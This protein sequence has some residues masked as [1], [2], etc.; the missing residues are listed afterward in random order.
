MQIVLISALIL[1]ILSLPFAYWEQARAV[2][3]AV[4]ITTTVATS[5]TFTTS[6]GT[7]DEFGTVT[8]GTP[9]FATTTLAVATN[10]NLGWLTSLSGDNK[11]LTN[12]NLQ[13]GTPPATSTQI[14]DQTEWIPGTATTSAGNA[15]RITSLVNSNNVLAFRVMTASSTNGAP[16][17][18]T[19]WWGTADN[20]ADNA[21]TLWS[22]VPS[23][24]VQ[25]TIGNAGA[26]SYS[27]STHINTVLYYLNT[28]P[29]QLTGSYSAPLTFTAVG[30]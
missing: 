12:N 13:T 29:T 23:S 24:T 27:A 2:T 11:N 28:A 17:Y 16:F 21:N 30:N 20:Y 22:G 3:G 14:T 9:R 15:V 6:T 1:L 8:P 18:S 7:A 5:L 10:D 4:T 26:G 19:T 25:R